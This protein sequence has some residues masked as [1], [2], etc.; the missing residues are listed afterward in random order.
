MFILFPVPAGSDVQQ[1][2]L[3]RLGPN[4]HVALQSRKAEVEYLRRMVEVLFPYILPP[5]AAKSK[6]VI[7][8]DN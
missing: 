1:I 3:E 2:T 8:R 4:M 7:I 6:Y 5:A